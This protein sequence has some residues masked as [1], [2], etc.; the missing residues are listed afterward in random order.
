MSTAVMRTS[1]FIEAF[2]LDTQVAYPDGG[3]TYN[4]GVFADVRCPG[5]DG[6]RG[7]IGNGYPAPAPIL[8]FI[9]V[10][11]SEVHFTFCVKAV[12]AAG[13][14]ATPAPA[15]EVNEAAP[16][17]PTAGAR[18]MQ[19]AAVDH[20]ATDRVA[21]VFDPLT[22]GSPIATLSPEDAWE[23]E[24]EFTITVNGREP[25]GEHGFGMNDVNVRL[26]NG[27][28]GRPSS[29]GRDQYVATNAP[30]ADAPPSQL[31]EDAWAGS[32]EFLL[33][34]DGQP[35]TASRDGRIAQPSPSREAGGPNAIRSA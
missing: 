19:D 35:V 3:Y 14:K 12:T 2:G 9:T 21:K 5:V 1:A 27:G 25:G 26:I 29:G 30:P 33:C 7:R 32:T 23:A 20:R 34:I 11:Q 6:V 16:G 8:S 28:D 31:P 10:A 22:G 13:L 15:D 18:P 24:A 4:P 17:H